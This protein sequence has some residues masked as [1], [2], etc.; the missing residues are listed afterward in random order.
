[1]LKY[2]H[3]DDKSMFKPVVNK[4]RKAF[5]IS[6]VTISLVTKCHTYVKF[7]TQIQF[8]EIPRSVLLDAHAILSRGGFLLCDASTDWRFSKNPLVTDTPFIRF[9]CGVNLYTSDGISIGV[10]AI[11]DRYPRMA[12]SEN[13]VTKLSEIASDFMILL[14][15]PYEKILEERL[16]K[17]RDTA[18]VID[19]EL[20]ELSSKLGR[21]T[22]KG[23]YATVFERDGSG[24]PY[25]QDLNFQ[26]SKFVTMNE[27]VSASGVP[28]E[29]QRLQRKVLK[30]DSLTSAF[31]IVCKTIAETHSF[32]LVCIVEV[33]LVGLFSIAKKYWPVSI[34]KVSLESFQYA[35]KLVKSKGEEKTQA[36][37]CAA[38]SNQYSLA[39]LLDGAIAKKVMRS[40]CGFYYRNQSESTMKSGVLMPFFQGD[41]RLVPKIEA[42]VEDTIPVQLRTSGFLVCAFAKSP[43][44]TRFDS[45]TVSSI[46]DHVQV[47]R[48]VHMAK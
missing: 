43:D 22:S 47:V 1:M 44:L 2:P 30:L 40:D 36:R 38:S 18:G 13:S 7:E 6:G 8:R 31:V 48:K 9:Y 21:A 34:E 3:W 29:L 16:R 12:F 20:V 32:D 4:V 11:H 23:N 41:I 14:E 35:N 24:N 25:A 17:M 37:V 15:T 46:F 42:A 39:K 19:T 28:E 26:L 33:R 5:G 10:L 45:A 27:Q